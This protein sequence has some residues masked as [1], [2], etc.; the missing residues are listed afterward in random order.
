MS[1]SSGAN[2]PD[3]ESVVETAQDNDTPRTIKRTV[4]EPE[5]VP[6]R[7]SSSPRRSDPPKLARK[8]KQTSHDPSNSLSSNGTDPSLPPPPPKGT[9]VTN[10]SS[11]SQPQGA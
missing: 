7:T 1:T 10:S 11:S 6:V 8:S 9:N 4:Q 5:S 2:N 3:V